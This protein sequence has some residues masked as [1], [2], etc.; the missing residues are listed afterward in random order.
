MRTNPHA[1]RFQLVAVRHGAAAAALLLLVVSAVV[2]GW[3]VVRCWPFTV[4]DAFIT[5]RYAAH[6]AAGRGAE[7]N[8]GGQPIEGYTSV[9]WMLLMSLPHALHLDAVAVSKIGGAMSAALA[10]V[11]AG[12][13]A[14]SISGTAPALRGG[15]SSGTAPAL[16]GG[17]S[18][19]HELEQRTARWLAAGLAVLMLACMPASA[20]HAVSGMETALYALLITVH[21]VALCR[22]LD[23]VSPPVS[24]PF[25]AQ[26]RRFAAALPYGIAAL[27]LCAG[28]TR[29]EGNLFVGAASLVVALQLPR[30]RARQLLL[31]LLFVHVLP[32][33]GYFAWRSL[34]YAKLLPLPF[35]VKT[36]VEPGLLAGAEQGLSFLREVLI[37]KPYVGLAFAYGAY[38]YRRRMA[39]PLCAALLVWI[40]FLFPAPVMAFAQRY[41]YPLVPIVF[42]V[43]AAGAVRA[44]QSVRAPVAVC[45]LGLAAIL[46]A[47]ELRTAPSIIAERVDYGRGLARAHSLLGRRLSGVRSQVPRPLIALLDCGAIPYYS[48]WETLDTYGLNDPTIAATGRRDPDYVFRQ[49]PAVLVVI[50]TDH[51]A[52]E[53]LFEWERPLLD[54][55]AQRGFVHAATYEFLPNYFLW[56]LTP[57][58]SPIAA[59]VAQN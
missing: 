56:V 55:S 22:L 48:G 31:A 10:A 17:A 58:G 26:R 5:L 25:L 46:V 45:A 59:A 57:A 4:D 28:L 32:G 30:E 36:S 19:P 43:A 34:H 39:A 16:R 53:P 27:G 11:A 12:G 6:L 8:A 49:E 2:F 41:L 15:A 44:M 14:F 20:I 40:F 54:R 35:Y 47:G 50:S 24:L 52:F 38:V 18:I 13:L 42:A 33:A 9:L 21:A 23:D 1:Q 7:W 3:N 37:D 51:D 29:P